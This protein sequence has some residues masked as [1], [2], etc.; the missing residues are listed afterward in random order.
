MYRYYFEKLDV[1]KRSRAFANTLYSISESFP[2]EENFGLTSQLRR[3]ATSVMLNIA[4]GNSRSTNKDQ[5]QYTT[6]A[7]SSLMEAMAVLMLCKDQRFISAQVY[8]DLREDLNS[9]AIR[10]NALKKAQLNKSAA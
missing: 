1:F 6:V 9:I 3:A 4:E 10:L 2:K 7:Y 5:A 8:F